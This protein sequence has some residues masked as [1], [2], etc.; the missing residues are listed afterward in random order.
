MTYI[1]DG[2]R[3][4]SGRGDILESE[5]S[6]VGTSSIDQGGTHTPEINDAP[7][8]WLVVPAVLAIVIAVGVII[9]ETRKKRA[10]NAS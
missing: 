4:T 10:K 1:V 6:I 3:H 8:M 9:W 2:E 7:P 5:Y